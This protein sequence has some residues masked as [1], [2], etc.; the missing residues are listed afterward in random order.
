MSNEWDIID[1]QRQQGNQLVV[2]TIENV[3]KPSPAKKKAGKRKTTARAPE[4][5]DQDE[6]DRKGKKKAKTAMPLT[7]HRAVNMTDVEVDKL[8][9]A[10][11][12]A[13]NKLYKDTF[14][15]LYK[16]GKKPFTDGSGK[17]IWVHYKFLHR[18]P[19]G[20]LVYR[21]LEMTRLKKICNQVLV[22]ADYNSEYRNI[23]VLP[24]KHG[25]HGPHQAVTFWETLPKRTSITEKSHYYII[26]G[27]HTVEAYKQLI[28]KGD[29]PECDIPLA[30]TFKIIP[31]WQKFDLQRNDIVHLSKSLNQ[32]I[33]GE[34][35]EQSFMQQLRHAHIRWIDMGCPQPSYG[36][37]AHSTEYNVSDI[38]GWSSNE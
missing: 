26:G 23:T 20:R 5:E 6:E 11:I 22:D 38:V 16:W 12:K 9:A 32:N 35:K 24:L 21:G 7:I 29:I 28:D 18:A 31:I 4:D 3:A 33:V 27:Q 8:S 19:P 17:P 37:R 14:N 10:E 13:M 34:Q 15:P 30:S 36:G 25:P 2:P 1:E